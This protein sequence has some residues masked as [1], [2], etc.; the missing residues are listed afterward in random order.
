MVMSPVFEAML[1]S[2]MIE[3]VAST[4]AITHFPTLP[5]EAFIEFLYKGRLSLESLQE[6]A[7]E[8]W[9]LGDK[10]DVPSLQEV[11]EQ[12]IEECIE[13]HNVS[14]LLL[15]SSE[16]GASQIRALCIEFIV[17]NKKMLVDRTLRQL[18]PKDVLEEIIASVCDI[19]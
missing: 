12:H 10:Y 9:S 4:I 7:I 18:M 1:S 19:A 11:V 13:E 14:D 8:L 5:V 17:N 15:K 6:N 16:L 2:T 3:N